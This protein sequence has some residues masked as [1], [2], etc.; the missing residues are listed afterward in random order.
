MRAVLWGKDHTT[1]GEVAV[2]KLDGDIAVALS[3]GLRRK[4]YRYT[5]LNEDA[6]AAVAGARA[7]LLVVAD[8]HNGWSSTEA[9][10]TAVL[11]RL[12]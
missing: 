6:V 2:E 9:A 4:A 1:L 12:G 8:G 5:D 10:V 11:D 7:T 3:R